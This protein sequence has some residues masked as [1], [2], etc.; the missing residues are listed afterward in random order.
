M[1]TIG[2]LLQAGTAGL[3]ATPGSLSSPRLD[4]E[5]LLGFALGVPRTTLYAHPGREVPP[6]IAERYRALLKQRTTHVPIAYLT[7][8]R[9]FWSL[10]LRV[11]R[12]T[13]IPRPETELLVS[14][15]LERVPISKPTARSAGTLPRSSPALVDVGTGSGAIALALASE[16]PR[17]TVVATDTST[18]ALTVARRNAIDFALPNVKFV[19]T[20]WLS[21]FSKGCFDIVVSNPPYIPAGDAH[22]VRGDVAHEP[23][24]A[25][26][27]GPDGLDALGQLAEQ[28]PRH[29][30]RNGWLLVEHGWDQGAQ[31]RML[32]ERAGLRA[33]GTYPDCA[34]YARVTAGRR[35]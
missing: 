25:L 16:R 1:T 35:A 26:V 7:G 20:S 3:S 13:L 33:V 18:G 6:P 31:V 10:S 24:S 15:V 8:Q 27:A 17:A 2:A 28:A 23:R 30:H 29:L 9:E 34:G 11:T 5:V 21:C 12:D 19:Q 4:A 14:Q 32:F 22:L